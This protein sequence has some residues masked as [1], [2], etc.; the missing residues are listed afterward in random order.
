VNG[1]RLGVNPTELTVSL[2]RKHLNNYHLESGKYKKTFKKKDVPQPH[3]LNLHFIS[4]LALELGAQC[5]LRAFVSCIHLVRERDLLAVERWEEA[6]FLE[7]TCQAAEG[8]DR[9]ENFGME[10]IRR[11][12]YSRMAGLTIERYMSLWRSLHKA[13]SVRIAQKR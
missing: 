9:D 10:K 7:H 6:D 1:K 11:L 5:P 3:K 2:K 12:G 8:K 13:N 4:K